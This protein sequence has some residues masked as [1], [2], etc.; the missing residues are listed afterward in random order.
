[1]SIETEIS[2]ISNAKNKLSVK[3]KN[4]GL[5][6]T[7]QRG[8]I[9]GLAELFDGIEDKG[10]ISLRVKEG[11]TF[12]IPAGY[13]NGRG[14]VTGIAGGG[15]YSL[16]Q[17]TVIP[18]KEQQ[19]V[20]PD[21]GNYGLSSVT[22]EPIPDNYQDAHD[23][24]A[25][26][27]EILAGKKAI[28]VVPTESGNKITKIIGTMNNNGKFE[29]KLTSSV[30]SVEIPA[31]YHNGEGSVSIKTQSKTIEPNESLQTISPDEGFLFS[32]VVV[33]PIPT[34]YKDTTG[35]KAT[36]ED[37]L[38]DKIVITE[39]GRIEGT[40]K[41]NG[42]VTLTMSGLNELNSTIT[43]PKGYHDG[44]GTVSLT[45]EIETALGEI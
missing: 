32:S 36:S 22:V 18:T 2:R 45:N 20:T 41:N 8:K 15:D 40:M 14:T 12:D 30:T 28:G 16:Q 24:S 6:S 37:V 26:S 27:T 13:H 33:N 19:S 21:A 43:I 44:T 4:M 34:K 39:N 3:A 29:R 38:K 25:L 1:M 10:A 42:K 35:A 7:E 9:E 11:E 31:G 5:G 17:K 23:V